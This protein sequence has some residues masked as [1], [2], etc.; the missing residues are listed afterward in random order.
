VTT[1]PDQ[2]PEETRIGGYRLIARIGEGGMGV[3]HL[4]QAPDGSRVALK[5]LRPHII[6][7]D[8]ARERLAGRSAR[9]AGSPA[10]GSRR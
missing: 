6:G 4:A 9:C 7:D 10:P 1:R 8:E 3:V 2:K 5:V